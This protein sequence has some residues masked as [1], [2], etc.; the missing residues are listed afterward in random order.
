MILINGM[1][2]KDKKTKRIVIRANWL[3]KFGLAVLVL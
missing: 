2:K 3:L 1:K